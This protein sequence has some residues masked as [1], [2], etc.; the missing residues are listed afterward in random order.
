MTDKSKNMI[1]IISK[2]KEKAKPEE[3]TFSD[4]FSKLFP[5]TNENIAEQEGKINDLP[6]N[7]LEEIFSKID[8]DEIPKELKFFAGG[9]NNEF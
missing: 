6:L 9:L 4:E 3:I 5:E 7:N 2:V 1:E 8:K